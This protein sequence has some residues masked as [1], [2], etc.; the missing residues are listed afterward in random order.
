MFKK[1]L[2]LLKYP[3]LTSLKT[4]VSNSI[5]KFALKYLLECEVHFINVFGK[6]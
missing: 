5:N 2:I 1:C 3:F 6:K 4:Q